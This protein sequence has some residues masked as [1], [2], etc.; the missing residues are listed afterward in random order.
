MSH[1]KAL[2]TAAQISLNFVTQH[3]M[4]EMRARREHLFCLLRDALGA[5][6][7]KRNGGHLDSTHG[8]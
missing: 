8:G 4:D 7:V 1:C 2:G 6:V 3:A 5:D